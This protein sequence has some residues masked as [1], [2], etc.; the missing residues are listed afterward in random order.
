MQDGEGRN[1]FFLQRTV[2]R[3][4]PF[5]LRGKSWLCRER[6]ELD[7]KTQQVNKAGNLHLKKPAYQKAK[8]T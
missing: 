6:L 7:Q 5:S 1:V 4:L 8:Q 2:C 3:E